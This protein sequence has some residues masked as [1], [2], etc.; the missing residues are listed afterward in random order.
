MMTTA[1][2][3][4]GERLLS[5][6]TVLAFLLTLEVVS[7]ALT[8]PS[9]SSVL[10]VRVKHVCEA[11]ELWEFAKLL[12]KEHQQQIVTWRII[13]THST[14]DILPSMPKFG[15]ASIGSVTW[16]DSTEIHNA[17]KRSRFLIRFIVLVDEPKD[18]STSDDL[19]FP[20]KCL[21]FQSNGPT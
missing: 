3:A 19:A 21:R 6:S 20:S 16:L 12:F 5:H 8:A 18:L 2:A 11:L 10:R 17:E 4:C 15:K 7:D 1:S 9:V 14:K 13:L